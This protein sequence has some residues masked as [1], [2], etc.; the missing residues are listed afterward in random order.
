MR[1]K[2]SI[3]IRVNNNK[4]ENNNKY[5]NNIYSNK[6]DNKNK[7]KNISYSNNNIVITVLTGNNKSDY[8]FKK[9]KDSVKGRMKPTGKNGIASIMITNEKSQADWEEEKYVQ[10]MLNCA[11][12][13]EK[14][15]VSNY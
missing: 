8:S 2:I 11:G 1:I 10:L 12:I 5:K 6:N 13:M 3:R 15:L 9:A 7:Y 4:N 14:N